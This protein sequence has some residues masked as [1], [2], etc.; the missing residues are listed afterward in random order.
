[1]ALQQLYNKVIVQLKLV[2]DWSTSVAT[3]IS[4]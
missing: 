2:F 1:L 3:I 4:Y